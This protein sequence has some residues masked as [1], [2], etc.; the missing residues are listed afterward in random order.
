MPTKTTLSL[1]NAEPENSPNTKDGSASA[2]GRAT[3]Q[4]YAESGIGDNNNTRTSAKK[5]SSVPADGCE[6]YSQTKCDGYC[7]EHYNKFHLEDQLKYKQT[8]GSQE[9][10]D[11]PTSL[12]EESLVDADV[13]PKTEVNKNDVKTS[14]KK[15]ITNPKRH[16]KFKGCKKS[17]QHKCDGYCKMHYKSTHSRGTTAVA[18]ANN[19][20]LKRDKLVDQA[21]VATKS[22]EPFVS[23]KR[24][25]PES[26]T[27]KT[28]R[29]TWKKADNQINK[30]RS[31]DKSHDTDMLLMKTVESSSIS[32]DSDIDS[33]LRDTHRTGVIHAI[34][35][36]TTSIISV[37]AWVNDKEE[38]PASPLRHYLNKS[39][40]S[41]VRFIPYSSKSNWLNTYPHAV[42]ATDQKG[43]TQENILL[44]QPKKTMLP[45]QIPDETEIEETSQVYDKV[46]ARNDTG[47]E[48]G[49]AKSTA[50]TL[51]AET[52]KQ[53]LK[54]NKQPK[55]FEA[56]LLS[57]NE[58]DQLHLEAYKYFQWLF[59]EITK[60]RSTREGKA[61][62]KQAGIKYKTME[63]M[64]KKIDFVFKIKLKFADELPT[65]HDNM[66]QKESN[67][68]ES[69]KKSTPQNTS[70]HLPSRNDGS[71][72]QSS[73][74]NGCSKHED[75]AQKEGDFLF[76]K[77]IDELEG[78]TD[79]G[80]G[81]AFLA[82]SSELTLNESPPSVAKDTP[83]N[84]VLQP[85]S[86]TANLSS[87]PTN[88]ANAS[89]NKSTPQKDYSSNQM[90]SELLF[91]TLLGGKLRRRVHDKRLLGDPE[92]DE[93]H[94]EF[95]K[96]LKWLFVHLIEVHKTSIG[97]N[98]TRTFG[99][100][101]VPM[102]NLMEKLET[103][104][105]SINDAAQSMGE[106]YSP[107]DAGVPFLEESLKD[108]LKKTS[109]YRVQARKAVPTKNG[110]RRN[111]VE[112]LKLY[113]KEHGH[114]NVRIN[115]I[116]AIF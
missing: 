72:Q 75:F 2:G 69:I 5:R 60:L 116:C 100:F 36:H 20:E 4:S 39:C 111:Y 68:E 21:G 81:S 80:T 61:A 14:E 85:Q 87:C 90:D 91:N 56:A 104:F 67:D 17:T 34:H 62:V 3:S 82:T 92:R 64:L 47:S 46:D 26:T 109:N 49:K 114:C 70:Q 66:P 44:H 18:V 33:A 30:A 15:K 113:K 83:P 50:A 1:K 102:K 86:N 11:Y 9:G 37:F 7:H 16:C 38:I 28:P 13:G 71:L 8:L 22:P 55:L 89:Q 10:K 97:R 78:G 110:G 94:V 31:S 57:N 35:P 103:T 6:K 23:R 63:N 77:L 54:V 40:F 98:K 105:K 101:V 29:K 106:D 107:A 25:P 42:I 74:T 19:F 27:D 93:L 76:K 99:I 12:V 43:T 88:V 41:S 59:K 32:F 65:A 108:V 73:Q 58:R 84:A 51:E 112:E 79:E 53:C 52:I 96:Y 115:H 48:G 95:Y 24:E 45:I